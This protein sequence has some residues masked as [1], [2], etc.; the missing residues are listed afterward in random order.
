M[1]IPKGDPYCVAGWKVMVA[2]EE[3]SGV[4]QAEGAQ[5]GGDFRHS[6][7]R[8]TGKAM[9]EH[10][11]ER[12]EEGSSGGRMF[13][14]EGAAWHQLGEGACPAC[15]RTIKQVVRAGVWSRRR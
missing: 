4:E 2:M 3:E 9:L 14:A 1:T 12:G 15:L 6:G 8:F 10:R 7:M 5:E 13:Q 11:C